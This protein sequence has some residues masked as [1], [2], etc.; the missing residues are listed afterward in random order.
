MLS[1][2]GVSKH[3]S[4]VRVLDDVNLLIED[5]EV[6][7]LLG[8]NGAGKSTLIK[9]LGGQYPDATGVI[10]LDGQ[11]IDLSSPGAA[12][13]S[14][15]G[16]VNQEFDLVPE[17]TVAENIF[18]GME[19][20][21]TNHKISLPGKID[22]SRLILAATDLL[23]SYDLGLTP[24]NQVGSLSVGAQQI[25]EIARVL[26]L[27][28]NVMIFDEPT[29]RLGLS[30]KQRL[31]VIFR[32]LRARGK[33]II[34]VTHYLDEVLEVADRASVMRDGRLIATR[35]VAETSVQALSRIM[36]GEDIRKTVKRRT[37]TLGPQVLAAKNLSVLDEFEDVD[38]Q[39]RS[40][41][42]LGLV[43]HLGSGR[44]ALTRSL[45]GLRP[46]H[47]QITIMHH[48]REIRPSSAAV[49]FVP[50]NRHLEGIFPELSVSSNIAM[51]LLQRRPLFG[52][53]PTKTIAEVGEGTI[54]TLQIKTSGGGQKISQLSGGNQQKAVFGRSMVVQP[55]LYII[56]SP[57][58]GVDIRAAA[59]LQTEIFRLAD[60]GAG[61][62]L[63]T[64]DLDEVILLADRVLVMLRGRIVSEFHAQDLTRQHLVAAMG[65][66]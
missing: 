43:G 26:A 3:F 4:G 59:E 49:G 2:S 56:E 48:G 30:D 39:V 64:D 57:T 17:M 22:R 20:L 29:A 61:I 66:G 28:S 45:I 10:K 44:H 32:A 13:R 47:G 11:P 27:Q 15:I 63:S 9:I 54:K 51:G 41:E 35:T 58:V 34:F 42:I 16:V 24:G 23:R 46:H 5:G 52:R 38:L 25:T 55:S 6:H 14:G 50:E 60:Q 19:T 12:R 21:D 1:I 18:L 31:F 8:A 33:K 40:G 7:A 36:V 53:L 37:P 65:A 62:I